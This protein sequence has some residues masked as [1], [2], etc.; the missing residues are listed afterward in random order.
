MKKIKDFLF[1]KKPDIFNKS[2]EV[3]HQL[4]KNSWQEWENRYLEASEYDWNQH[5][6][7][8]YNKKNREKEESDG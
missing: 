4:K 8:N 5:S 2:G 3:Q 6:G 7:T 1:G